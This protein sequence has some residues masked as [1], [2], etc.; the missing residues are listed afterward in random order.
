MSVAA[1]A[2][3]VVAV[4]LGNPCDTRRVLLRH[5]PRWTTIGRADAPSSSTTSGTATSTS[6]TR[7]ISSSGT[8]AGS[9]TPSRNSARRDRPT[10]S[11]SVARL[12]VPTYVQTTRPGS[13]QTVLEIDEELVDLVPRNSVERRPG[14]GV[15]V[16]IGD[17][18]QSLRGLPDDSAD[19]IVGDA[20]GGRS[21]P[22][23]LAT[24]EFVEDIDRVLRPGGIYVANVIDGPRQRF[25]SSYAATVATQ[26]E[27]VSV[28]LGESAALGGN[29]NSVIIASDDP[30]DVGDLDRRRADAGDAGR[31]VDGFADFTDQGL[32]LTDDFAPVDQL[33]TGTR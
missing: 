4:A 30:F 26:F 8:S 17:G 13:E 2:A 20:F 29:G 12:T 19:V 6:T 16:I 25:L 21:V 1:G 10:S 31:F 32:V 18:R 28:V 24:T 7:H 15:E 23:H 11:T 3:L 27:Q 22:W 14:T 33:L 5:D 9:S